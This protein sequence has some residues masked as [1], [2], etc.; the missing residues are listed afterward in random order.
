MGGAEAL[1]TDFSIAGLANP[2]ALFREAIFN[3]V[4]L[5]TGYAVIIVACL[6]YLDSPCSSTVVFGVFLAVGNFLF[7]LI[8]AYAP[9]LTLMSVFGTIAVDIFCVRPLSR[10]LGRYCHRLER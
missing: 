7:A 2:D 4:F 10:I 1:L 6:A 5:D 3:G 9:G 8:R